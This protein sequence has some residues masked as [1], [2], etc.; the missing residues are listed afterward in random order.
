MGK[1]QYEWISK[2]KPGDNESNTKSV[3][4]TDEFYRQMDVED[5]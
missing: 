1:V 2:W 3:M 5:I 4:E